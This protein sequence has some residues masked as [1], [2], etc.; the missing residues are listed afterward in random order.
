MGSV[1]ALQ[2]LTEI[3]LMSRSNGILRRFGLQ[4]A[5]LL[6]TLILPV[7]FFLYAVIENPVWF[8]L[9]QLLHGVTILSMMVFGTLYVSESLPAKW[10]ATGQGLYATFYGGLGSSL[11]LFMAGVLNDWLG[12]RSVWIGSAIVS[13]LSIL[14]LQKSFQTVGE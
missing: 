8:L 11:G 6:G 4:I 9:A 7:R 10:R 13:V 1:V 2:A 12:I 5:I 14:I 3:P